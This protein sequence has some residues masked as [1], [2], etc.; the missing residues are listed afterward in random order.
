[1]NKETIK[2]CSQNAISGILMDILGIGVLIIGESGTG[3]SESALDLIFKG[4]KLISDDLVDIFKS[5]NGNLI[6]KSPSLIKNLMEIRGL[7][8]INIKKIFGP[9]SVEKKK[10][11]DLVIKLEKWEKEEDFDRLGIEELTH[12]IMGVNFP[13]IKIPVAVG[14]NLSILIEVAVRNF[15][16]KRQGYDSVHKLNNKLKKMLQ[17]KEKTI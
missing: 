13:L 2:K 8:I 7:G 15:I 12:E 16:L 10:K 17:A 14:R 11:I 3:K 6:G 9:S 4:H 5:K 1:M